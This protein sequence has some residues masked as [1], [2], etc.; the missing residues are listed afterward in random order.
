[1]GPWTIEF[2]FGTDFG[3]FGGTRIRGANGRAQTSF[4]SP[5]EARRITHPSAMW[6]GATAAVRSAHDQG[7][8]LNARGWRKPP[9][10]TWARD[11]TGA[12]GERSGHPRGRPSA[13]SQQM[14]TSQRTLLSLKLLRGHD[15]PLPPARNN[16]Y[17]RYLYN[18]PNLT[19]I[20]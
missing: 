20:R 1:M 14:R 9:P 6:G 11:S 12:S 13:S 15:V 19:N 7:A 17:A 3:R 16:A 8:T 10:E 2:G 5:L 4:P 18:R